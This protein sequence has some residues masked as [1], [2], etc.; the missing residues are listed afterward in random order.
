MTA[1][2]L[3]SVIARNNA[4]ADTRDRL[5][6][7]AETSIQAVLLKLNCDLIDGTG[8]K[9]DAIEVDTRKFA[10]LAVTIFTADDGDA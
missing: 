3:D 7:A 6:T 2:D 8:C 4:M 10:N 5:V 1:S 9:V